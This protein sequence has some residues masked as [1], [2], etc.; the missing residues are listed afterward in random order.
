MNKMN[1]LTI[2]GIFLVFLG[3]IGGIILALGQAHSAQNDKK[4][5][6]STTKS[7]NKDLKSRIVELKEERIKLSTMLEERDKRI[8]EQNLKI[9][10]LNNQI[11][12]KSI[13]LGETA[14]LA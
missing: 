2:I 10:S 9:E 5:I 14:F 13:F 6:I 4:E 12:S 8:S 3:G 1:T 11:I 7:E